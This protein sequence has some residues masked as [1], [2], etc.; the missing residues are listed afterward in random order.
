MFQNEI[1]RFHIGLHVKGEFNNPHAV[2]LRKTAAI[3]IMRDYIRDGFTVID[4]TGYW[5]DNVE[6]GI[7]VEAITAKTL[8]AS[9]I[10]QQVCMQLHQECVLVT[11]APV[12]VHFEERQYDLV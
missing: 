1:Y 10:C 9:V 4:T 12:D 2:A 5:D 8:P 11:I 3:R 7:I 6:P